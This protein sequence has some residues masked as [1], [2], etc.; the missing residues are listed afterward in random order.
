MIDALQFYV[1]FPASPADRQLMIAPNL[2]FPTRFTGKEFAIPAESRSPGRHD[3]QGM[4]APG[5]LVIDWGGKLAPGSTALVLIF[6]R[7]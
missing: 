2:L 5:E 6:S 7:T 3:E 1:A 4:R